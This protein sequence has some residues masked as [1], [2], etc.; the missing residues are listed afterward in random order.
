[1]TI[2]GIQKTQGIDIWLKLKHIVV[3]TTWNKRGPLETI[4]ATISN[5]KK[6]TC[7]GKVKQASK[8]I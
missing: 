5:T 2:T 1:M 6:G 4:A 3:E 7:E 8:E